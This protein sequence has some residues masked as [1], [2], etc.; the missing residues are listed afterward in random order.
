MIGEKKKLSSRVF[1][2]FNIIIMLLLCVAMVYPMLYEL[3]ISLSEAK[4]LFGYAG[5]VYGPIGFT[6]NNYTMVFANEQILSGFKNTLFLLVVGI[7]LNLIMTCLAAYFLSRHGM[8][9][10]KPFVTMMLITMY[11]S[12]GLIPCYI[13]ISEL[14]L[15]DSLWVLILPGVLSTSNALVLSSF[16]R[17]IPESIVESVEIDGGGHVR[18]LFQFFVPLSTAAMAVMVLYYG[19]S[20]WNGWF[21]AKIYLRDAKKFPLQL[22]LQMM[23]TEVANNEALGISTDPY[24]E[25]LSET[26]KAATTIVVTLPILCIYPLLQKYFVKG[27]MLGSLK[28]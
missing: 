13:N 7:P 16:F 27:V 25:Q 28:E 10:R 6:W 14:G 24:Y 4:K 2:T 11:F 9:L 1:D 15:I 3:F 21:S 20:H 12:G 26:V 5:F 23:L 17:T 8:K 19:V 22:V 18:I